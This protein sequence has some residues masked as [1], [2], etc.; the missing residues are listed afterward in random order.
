MPSSSSKP[1]GN[2]NSTSEVPRR[3]VRQLVVVVSPQAQHLRR[4]AELDVP[5]E[6][7]LAPVLVPLRRLF[8]RYEEL[9]LHLLELAGPED[10]VLRGDL[11][12]EAL[13]D[14]GDAERRL[15]A[16][17]LQ[18]LAEVGE[19]ALRRL[20]TQ[21]GVG[22]GALD[23]AGLGL[24]HQVEL[25][26]LGE[27]VLRV[28]V[29][30]HV[31]IVELVEAEALLALGAVDER[32]GEVREVAGRLPHL[33]RAEDGGVDQHDVV[34]LLHHRAH[35]RLLDVAQQQRTERAVVVGRAE[36]AVDLRRLVDEAAAFAEADD[37][38]EVGGRHRRTRLPSPPPRLR[39]SFGGPPHPKCN[40]NGD[41]RA[42]CVA[43]AQWVSN[44][45]TALRRRSMWNSSARVASDDTSWVSGDSSRASAWTSCPPRISRRIV[46]APG[47]IA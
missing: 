43:S 31:G 38:F 4:D 10:P 30:A 44:I 2:V 18:D 24:E 22:A 27:A 12:A 20:G 6:A 36:A 28:A 7:L 46:S 3:I 39:C 1:H 42:G 23:R 33:R 19:H 35:P 5:V 11:V 37:L 29:R 26:G 41:W 9:H 25:A 34:A 13:A 21:I 47:L 15:L 8:G 40:A 32:V 45:A 17:G 14:L 16:G